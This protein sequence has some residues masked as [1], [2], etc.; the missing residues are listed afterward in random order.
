MQNI[1]IDTSPLLPALQITKKHAVFN[2]S[3]LLFHLISIMIKVFERVYHWL[4]FT[5]VKCGYVFSYRVIVIQFHSLF[6]ICY[7]Y[8]VHSRTR[9]RWVYWWISHNK[10]AWYLLKTLSIR[11]INNFITFC[12]QDC[13]NTVTSAK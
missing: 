2:Q 13:N 1:F 12:S 9:V 4:N 11:S 8:S 10:F 5:Q 7:L 6:S 3:I